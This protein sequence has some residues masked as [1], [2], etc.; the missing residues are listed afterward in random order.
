MYDWRV[1]FCYGKYEI[2]INTMD[3]FLECNFVQWTKDYPAEWG[4]DMGYL[5]HY[6]NEA[7]GKNDDSELV[8]IDDIINHICRLVLVR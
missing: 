8:T 4:N 2:W 5:M 6:S 7:F 3:E 1:D